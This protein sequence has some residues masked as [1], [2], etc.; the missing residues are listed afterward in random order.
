MITAPLRDVSEEIFRSVAKDNIAQVRI[1]LEQ[2]SGGIPP[3][4]QKRALMLAMNNNNSEMV[5]ILSQKGDIAG[6]YSQLYRDIADPAV[7]EAKINLCDGFESNLVNP[8]ALA[9]ACN[10][11]NMFE[12]FLRDAANINSWCT[13]GINVCAW[14]AI[15]NDKNA[16][17]RIVEAGGQINFKNSSEEYPLD[18][19]LKSKASKMARL[20][21]IK[22]G[23]LQKE[24]RAAMRSRD[25]AHVLKLLTALGDLE[26][27]NYKTMI[28]LAGIGGKSNICSL[29]GKD[30]PEET[31]L[32][33][34]FI[35]IIINSKAVR[36]V[37]GRS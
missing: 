22:E 33:R 13:D 31:T 10:N 17:A 8:I 12:F 37:T 19:A 32:Q 29:D 9:I 4:I 35:N 20:V 11:R 3:G 23:F 27:E 24:I 18:I 6:N 30:I 28:Y 21:R 7:K 36:G 16:L 34:M 25:K 14:A 26:A 5:R 15:L 1:L 2:C